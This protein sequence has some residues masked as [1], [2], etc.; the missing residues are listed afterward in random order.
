MKKFVFL[1]FFVLLSFYVLAQNDE[2]ALKLD[3]PFL[4]LPYQF[5]AMETVNHGFFSS[6]ANPSMEQSLAVAVNLHSSFHFGMISLFDKWKWDKI[7]G[8]FSVKNILLDIGL[9]AGDFVFSYSPGGWSWMHEEFHRAVL[10]RNGVNSFNDINTFPFGQDFISVNSI[11]DEDLIRFKDESPS[12]FVRARAAGIESHY[13]FI[14]RIQRNTFFYNQ[15][16]RFYILNLFMTYN[17]HNYIFTSTSSKWNGS[18]VDTRNMRETSIAS[19]DF[20]GDDIAAWAYDLFRPNEAFAARGVHPTGVGIDRYIKRSDLTDAERNY[21]GS[22]R[23]W[24]F[25][26]YVS[27]MLW[28]FDRIAIG[29]TGL[30]GNFA[31]RHLLTSFGTD[32]SLNI[33]LKNETFKMVFIF[34]NYLNYEHWF[35]AI[36]AEIVDFPIS[37]G[38]LY[39]YV[40]PRFLIGIQPKNQNFKTNSPEFFGLAECRVDFNLSKYILP[41]FEVSMKTDGWVAGNEFLEKNASIRIGISARF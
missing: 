19:R 33:F 2:P 34:H 32:V 18:E 38:N 14:D 37:L 27:P 12:D 13:L 26:N 3:L 16:L 35:P 21:I 1:T 8:W 11:A 7:L 5:D 40:S 41:Y 17:A 31:F 24:H 25:F 39:L 4:D 10:T 30:Y 36:E 6:Y 20:S 15:E 9:L 28:G 23:Y 22:Q 29:D